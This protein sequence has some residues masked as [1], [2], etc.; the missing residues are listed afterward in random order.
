MRRVSRFRGGQQ[1]ANLRPQLNALVDAVNGPPDTSGPRGTL[2]GFIPQRILVLE[3]RA[4]LPNLVD[5]TLSRLQC[6]LADQQLNPSAQTWDVSLPW[7]FTDLTRGGVSYVYTDINNRTADGT[8]VQQLTPQYIVQDLIMV[9]EFEQGTAWRDLNVDG[10]QW[11]K[12][13]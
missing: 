12:V 9:G 2:P 5:P 10:R 7:T 13:P 11:A 4:F 3:I 6:S 1:V 8:E